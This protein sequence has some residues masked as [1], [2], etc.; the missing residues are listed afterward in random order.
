MGKRERIEQHCSGFPAPW[1]TAAGP[2]EKRGTTAP[3]I[4]RGL[5]ARTAVPRSPGL[6]LIAGAGSARAPGRAAGTLERWNAG[7]PDRWKAGPRDSARRC[8]TNGRC[9]CAGRAHSVVCGCCRWCVGVVYGVWVSPPACAGESRGVRAAGPAEKAET[10]RAAARAGNSGVGRAGNPG[11]ERA[12]NLGSL[13]GCAPSGLSGSVRA[14]I[15][16]GGAVGVARLELGGWGG[17]VGVFGWVFGRVFGP[18][19]AAVVSAVV[20]AVH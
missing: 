1:T 6:L 3:Y 11:V 20:I 18:S 17:A 9:R 16:F 2:R 5:H 4:R 15:R 19:V 7:P 14:Y 8:V 10:G 12:G 13:G